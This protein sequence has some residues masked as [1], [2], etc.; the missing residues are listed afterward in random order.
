M[1]AD[2]SFALAMQPPGPR[3]ARPDQQQRKHSIF[4]DGLHVRIAV[5]VDEQR[6]AAENEVDADDERSWHWVAYA[7]PG[8]VPVGVVR[9][10]PP[11]HEGHQHEGGEGGEEEEEHERRPF[12]KIG[13]L[14]VLPAY[15]GKGLARLLVDTALGWAA[16]HAVEVGAGWDGLVLIHAQTDV[17]AMYAR[18][19]FKTDESMG[20]WVEEGIP[21]V[22][23]WKKL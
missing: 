11:P 2:D 5:F 3:I 4:R 1:S 12:I 18:L 23:M 8:R 17:E 16:E 6:C 10:V 19:G 20:R 21:H 14:A 22:G 13:R 9:L 7:G 15:R